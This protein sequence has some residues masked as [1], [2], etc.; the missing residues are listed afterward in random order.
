M[1]LPKN[2]MLQQLATNQRPKSQSILSLTLLKNQGH[3]NHQYLHTSH[4]THSTIN[5]QCIHPLETVLGGNTRVAKEIAQDTKI[6]AVLNIS[7]S[8][9]NTFSI[10]F[11]MMYANGKMPNSSFLCSQKNSCRLE[12]ISKMLLG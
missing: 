1:L 7:E 3:T 5:H 10:K 4:Q 6:N 8:A 11:M 2:H 12:D 9:E